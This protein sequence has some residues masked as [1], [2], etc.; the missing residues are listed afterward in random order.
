MEVR[1]SKASLLCCVAMAGV[2]GV[3]MSGP[4]TARHVTRKCYQAPAIPASHQPCPALPNCTAVNIEHLQ[5]LLTACHRV[6]IQ[7]D[8]CRMIKTFHRFLVLL[9]S[10]YTSKSSKF[11]SGK[12]G[13]KI[14]LKESLFG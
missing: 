13:V 2:A 14:F 11:V 3:L 8:T 7:G 10:S 1:C 12:C 6:N 5:P 4:A 9:H